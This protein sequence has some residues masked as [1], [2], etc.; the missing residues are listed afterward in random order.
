MK[1][2]THKCTSILVLLLHLD[3]N[4]HSKKNILF[5]QSAPCDVIKDN[6]GYVTNE[7]R[8][9]APLVFTFVWT[10]WNCN[11]ASVLA[12]GWKQGAQIFSL[13]WIERV[14]F[15]FWIVPVC[16][17]S[18]NKRK[19]A[20]KTSAMRKPSTLKWQHTDESQCGGGG[21]TSGITGIQFRP[22]RVPAAQ[23]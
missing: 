15:S 14:L 13:L 12:D 17:S 21:A 20:S 8:N 9:N 2:I 23:H 10:C 16:C 19:S 22:K 11:K 7:N 1:P 5:W 6:G 3:E 18:Q 4:G